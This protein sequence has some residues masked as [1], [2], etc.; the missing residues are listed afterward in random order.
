VARVDGE[1]RRIGDSLAEGLM[2]ARFEL[3][4]HQVLTERSQALMQAAKGLVDELCQLADEHQSAKLSAL[5]ESYR[6]AIDDVQRGIRS[7]DNLPPL[8]F[9]LDAIGRDVAGLLAA[10]QRILIVGAGEHPPD[11][12]SQIATVHKS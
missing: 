12:L 9:K 11:S 10:L 8:L 4:R 3:R 2:H 7:G 5:I 6:R 1:L